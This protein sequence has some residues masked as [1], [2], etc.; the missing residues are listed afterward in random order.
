MKFVLPYASIPVIPEMNCVDS[1]EYKYMHDCTLTMVRTPHG[2]TPLLLGLKRLDVMGIGTTHAPF[3]IHLP[4]GQL[5][6]NG[7]ESIFDHSQAIE[8]RSLFKVVLYFDDELHQYRVDFYRLER[9]GARD[10]EVWRHLN[11]DPTLAPSR[12]SMDLIAS[13]LEKL[14]V[15][16]NIP[17]MV[18]LSDVPVNSI[19]VL[20]TSIG[21]MGFRDFQ[22]Q[23][24]E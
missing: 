5:Y 24:S 22:Q 14:E 13:Y 20:T 9:E 1:Q 21:V 3:S 17:D 8:S 10:A 11:R 12:N 16:P 19:P 2:L 18:F 23:S 15:S 4:K 6:Y 7:Q